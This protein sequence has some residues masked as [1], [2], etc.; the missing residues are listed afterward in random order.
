MRKAPGIRISA[1]WLY[2]TNFVSLNTGKTDV[3]GR[4]K[5]QDPNK[6]MAD[7]YRFNA[8]PVKL[9][10]V[11]LYLKRTTNGHRKLDR[12]RSAIRFNGEAYLGKLNLVQARH[13][14]QIGQKYTR[15]K[16]K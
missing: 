6:M 14:G 5:T 8:Q 1:S 9:V 13:K 12:E 10:I 11:K 15:S 3:V 16:I 4:V 2:C 7:F